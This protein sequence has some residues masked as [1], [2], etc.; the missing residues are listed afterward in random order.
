MLLLY[1]WGGMTW[2]K[3]IFIYI[4]LCFYF[5]GNRH[6]LWPGWT[7]FTFH[8]ASTL[9]DHFQQKPIYDNTFT[10][11]YA[12]TLSKRRPPPATVIEPIYIPLCFYFILFDSCSTSF[13]MIYLHSIMLL[14][15]LTVW[16]LMR[17]ELQIYIP[18]CFYFISI[19]EFHFSEESLFTFH[20][21]STLSIR[22][23]RLTA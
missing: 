19:E 16:S 18:L 13:L 14:L 3:N 11:H 23:E 22:R 2:R 17:L 1:P 8:Y 6:P 4:P 9:S 7:Q 15:Y 12:S 5:I 10:F 21:A 20:Y